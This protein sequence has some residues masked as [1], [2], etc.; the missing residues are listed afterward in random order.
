MVESAGLHGGE[1]WV[2]SVRCWVTWWEVE[3]HGEVLGNMV[4]SVRLNSGECSITRE[5]FDCMEG[6]VGLPGDS[7]IRGSCLILAGGG[8]QKHLDND[9]EKIIT[10]LCAHEKIQPLTV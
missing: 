3:L 9:P 4:E 1:C 6:N 8:C 10:H 2:I 7:P 5:M